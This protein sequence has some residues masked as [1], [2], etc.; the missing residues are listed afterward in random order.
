MF[1]IK[2]RLIILIFVSIALP[3]HKF[4]GTRQIES[5]SFF[6]LACTNFA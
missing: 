4:G 6:A 3:L 1:P 5:K 2:K